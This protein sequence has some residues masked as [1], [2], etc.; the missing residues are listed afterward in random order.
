M[1]RRK[2]IGPRILKAVS[3]SLRLKVLNLLYERGPLSYTEIMSRLRLSPSRDAGRFAYHLKQ[4]LQ[5]D[6]IEPDVETK[7]YYITALGKRI[8]DFSDEIEEFAFRKKK[9]LVRTSRFAIETF[10]RNKISEALIREAGMPVDLAQKIAKETEKRL[11]KLKTKYLTA[12]LI[13]E[14]V[15]AILLER[16]LEEYRHKL[17]RLGLPVYD[18]TN[19]IKTESKA[20]SNVESIHRAA[21]DAV[22]E[23]YTLLNVLPRD[24][25]DAHLSG[26]LHINNLGYWV[27]KPNE[28]MHDIRF[29]F[30]NGLSFK[31]MGYLKLSC[32]PPREFKSALLMITDILR[33]AS[34]ELSGGQMIDFFNIFLAP[35]IKDV[36][37]EEVKE[38]LRLF[39][40]GINRTFLGDV[41]L[42]IELTMPKFLSETQALGADGRIFGSYG[43]HVDESL[44]MASV[45]LEVIFEEMKREPIFNPRLII[46]I[47]PETFQNSESE[48]LLYQAHKLAAEIGLPYFANLFPKEETYSSYTSTG[49]RFDDDWNGDW[50]L[51]TMRTGTIG[52]VTINLPR[53]AYDSE[54]NKEVFFEHLYDRLEMA[55][56]ALEIKYLK[57]RQRVREELLPFLMQKAGG[58]HYCRLENAS[59]IVSFV[60]LN[61]AVQAMSRKSMY[62]SKEALNLSEEIMGYISKVI[63]EN[64]KRPENRFALSITPCFEVARRLAELDIERYGWAKVRI[65]GDKDKPYYTDLSVIPMEEGI[66]LKEA[67]RIEGRLHRLTPGGHLATIPIKELEP[68]PD[69]LFSITEEIAKT[70]EI[71]FYRYT[72]DFVYCS[73]CQEIFYGDSLKCPLCRSVNTIIRSNCR[74]RTGYMLRHL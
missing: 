23:E 29:F 10:D 37:K 15:N 64:V 68:N 61:E 63:R 19:L 53:V 56:R 6:L 44:L 25:A 35:F 9:M 2:K 47:R 55:L 49:S 12:P 62:E 40:K 33:L 18:V 22:M 66:S 11:L 45:L 46:K 58:D 73:S 26:A 16:G 5:M 72:R 65:H 31:K 52:S 41:S 1:P 24:V 74:E 13:R 54:G 71:G 69:S 34:F 20:G 70:Y 51:D 48:S 17:T 60:G 50:E 38:Q 36:E 32:S 14:F 67:L 28:F 39:L 57:I 7:K 3:S 27:L 59:R 8:V 21:G 30:A 42:G 4:L 43:D